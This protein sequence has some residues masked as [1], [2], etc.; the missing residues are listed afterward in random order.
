[1]VRHGSREW[2]AACSDGRMDDVWATLRVDLAAMLGAPPPSMADGAGHAIP[3][4]A[5]EAVVGAV[6][7]P[8]A[9][10]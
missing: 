6:L 1:V 5:P 2:D 10:P 3:L 4:E 7:D 9:V 8:L